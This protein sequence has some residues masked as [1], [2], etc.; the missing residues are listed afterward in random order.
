MVC[1]IVFLHRFNP[2]FFLCIHIKD[3][4]LSSLFVGSQ[5][6]LHGL[7]TTHCKKDEN[8]GYKKGRTFGELVLWRRK[9]NR[10]IPS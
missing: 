5:S 4:C 7:Y 8:Q 3:Y 10:E 9:A 2:L 6:L 1:A